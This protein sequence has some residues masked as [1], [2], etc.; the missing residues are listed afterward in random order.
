MPVGCYK[1]MSKWIDVGWISGSNVIDKSPS[2]SCLSMGILEQVSS[3]AK[4]ILLLI[5]PAHSGLVVLTSSQKLVNLMFVSDFR[6]AKFT[7]TSERLWFRWIP[8]EA[9]ISTTGIMLKAIKEKKYTNGLH[10]Y[11]HSP[12]L[13]TEQWKG[14]PKIHALWYQVHVMLM[15]IYFIY[16]VSG[17]TSSRA[18][19]G[20]MLLSRPPPPPTIQCRMFYSIVNHQIQRVRSAVN[21]SSIWCF[22]PHKSLDPVAYRGFLAPGAKMGIGAPQHVRLASAKALSLAIG[23]G[24][25]RKPSRQRF[26]EHLDVNGTLFEF[27]NII[28]NSFGAHCGLAAMGRRRQWYWCL[29]PGTHRRRR[30]CAPKCWVIRAFSA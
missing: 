23:G 5:P 18:P 14:K 24:L 27:F 29:P 3:V 17:V 9:W 8:T 2:G 30:A 16:I 21:I 10:I 12:M 28:F 6:K 13:H 25:R 11:L 15:Y 22:L 20:K 4:N 19:G 1:Q 26:W 7:R